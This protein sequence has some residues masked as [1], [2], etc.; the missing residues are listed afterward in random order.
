VP[1]GAVFTKPAMS[2]AAFTKAAPNGDRFRTPLRR[3]CRE[4][5]VHRSRAFVQ[6]WWAWRV[7]LVAGVA[8]GVASCLVGCGRRGGSALLPRDTNI[9]IC[10]LDAARPDHMGCYGYPRNTTPT[11]DKLA[12]QSLVFENHFAAATYTETSTAS[13]F[14]SQHPYTHLVLATT[15]SI[16]K[17]SFTL[18]RG[19]AEVGYS[20]ALFSSNPFVAAKEGMAPDFQE[21]YGLDEVAPDA[22]QGEARYAP[23]H[24]LRSFDGWLRRSQTKPFFA[25]LHL[26]VP[27]VPYHAPDRF[28]T[29]FQGKTPPDYRPE[30]YHPGRYGVPIGAQSQSHPALPEWINL[31]DANMRYA[32]WAVEQIAGALKKAAIFDSTLLIITADHG[33]AFGEHGYTMHAG[34]IHSEV[35]HIPLII[36]FPGNRRVARISRLTQ[37]TDLL[38][39]ILELVGAEYPRDSVEGSPLVTVLPGQAAKRRDYVFTYARPDQ[40]CPLDTSKYMVRGED[41]SLLLYENGKWRALYDLKA[42]PGEK[43]NII[44][45]QP[46]A[47]EQTLAAFREFA[48]QQAKPPLHFADASAPPPSIPRRRDRQMTPQMEKEL[49]ALGYLK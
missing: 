42:D 6:R 14:T 34:A 25:Y 27:H 35:S 44:A 49:K 45:D 8:L 17:S 32:D 46:E 15:G 24:L 5:A 16:G 11:I 39:T 22:T 38:P 36:R 41:Y 10:V 13:L 26:L 29:L 20:T 28:T 40:S 3:S 9:V 43:H 4:M 47:A 23:E 21:V 37:N 7:A 18:A 31:Y 19:L 30:D 12:A 1:L 48:K 33:E 2:N